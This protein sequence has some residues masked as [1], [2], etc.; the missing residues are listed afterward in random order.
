MFYLLVVPALLMQA[1]MLAYLYQLRR[2]DSVLYRFCQIRR[3]VMALLREQ[4]ETLSPEEYHDAREL[5]DV[6]G[7]TIHNYQDQKSTMF[8][9]RK[10]LRFRR[11][12][13]RVRQ[14]RHSDNPQLVELHKRTA[15]AL[16]RGFIA[17]TPFFA[18][19][20]ALRLVLFG[21][22]TLGSMGVRKMRRA[23]TV[24]EETALL[25]QPPPDDFGLPPSRHA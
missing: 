20:L 3:D 10:F 11:S 8:D 7:F 16:V 21:A 1:V 15:M 9:G 12:A 14:A 19:E 5:L 2:H 17:Y 6:L 13:E 18:S 24:I 4:S 25:L 22:R 23:L